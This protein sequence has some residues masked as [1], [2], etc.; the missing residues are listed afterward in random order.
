MLSIRKFKLFISLFNNLQK[1][2]YLNGQ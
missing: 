1:N 2:I